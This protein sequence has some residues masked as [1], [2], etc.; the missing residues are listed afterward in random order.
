MAYQPIENYGMIGDMHSV[1]LVGTNGSID[2][3]CW[4][5]FDSPSVFAAILDDKKGGSFRI[6]PTDADVT[7]KQFYWPGTN[8]L[9][10]RFLGRE[11]ATELT[12]FMP[13]GAAAAQLGCRQASAPGERGARHHPLSHGVPAGLQLCA[14]LARGHARGHRRRVCLGRTAPRTGDERAAPRIRGRSGGRFCPERGRERRVRPARN[15]RRELR[16]QFVAGGGR[17]TLSGHR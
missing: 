15:E 11:G 9:V 14:R 17:G 4:P 3:L 12:D 5:R 7:C 1:A 6:A 13:V 2:W 16:R 8:V 10:T